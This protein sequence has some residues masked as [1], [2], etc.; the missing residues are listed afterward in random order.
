MNNNL[1][2]QTHACIIHANLVSVHQQGFLLRGPA[3]SGKTELC[4]LLLQRH[5]R[6]VADDAVAVTMIHRQLLGFA[7]S[8]T[9]QLLYRRQQ[10][11]VNIRQAFGDYAWLPFTAIDFSIQLGQVTQQTLATLASTIEH[12]AITKR[13]ASNVKTKSYYY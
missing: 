5:H 12:I 4:I 3:G 2:T 7:P 13:N 6:L 10:G 1:D 8:R 9:A 11:I